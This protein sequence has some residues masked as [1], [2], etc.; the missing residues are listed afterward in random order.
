[1]VTSA[2]C[3]VTLD[4]IPLA[5]TAGITW[6]FQTGSQPYQTIFT[7][8]KRH[9]DEYLS[10]KK[11][12]PLT[13]EIQ[14]SRGS[15]LKIK[16]VYILYE[17]PSDSP[18]RS[19]FLVSD[20]RWKWQYQ[21]IVRDFNIPR[22]TGELQA[23]GFPTQS[24]SMN[25]DSWDFYQYSLKDQKTRWKAKEALEDV[26]EELHEKDDASYEISSWS[27][28]ESAEEDKTISL[29]NVLLRDQGDI[30]VGKL[31]GFIPGTDLYVDAEGVTQVYNAADMD[32][33]EEYFGKLPLVQWG[34]DAP[35]MVDRAAIRPS[36]VILH[37]DKEIE[38]L[39]LYRDD[40]A[41]GG[42]A[43][44]QTSWLY[45][46]N[47]CQT[48]DPKTTLDMYNDETGEI[49][50]DVEVAAGTWVRFDKWLEAMDKD[51]PEDSAPWTFETISR[52]WFVGNLE[53]IL[54]AGGN[55][56]DDT[57]NIAA[58]V[59]A[60][61]QHFRQTFRISPRIM[62][63]VREMAATRVTVLDPV[64]GLRAPAAAWPQACFIPSK[65]AEPKAPIGRNVDYY[66][67]A[68]G[69][70]SS[71]G[72]LHAA[73]F[74]LAAPCSVNM[75][76]ADLG[77]F[78]LEWLPNPKG[79]VSEVIPCHLVDEFMGQPAVLSRD[80]RE[81]DEKP[82]L[83]DAKVESGSNGLQLA[84][85]CDLN[86]MMTFVPAGNYPGQMYTQE[87][88]VGDLDKI[89]QKGARI[90]NGDGPELHIYVEPGEMTSR[91]A[92]DEDASGKSTIRDMLGLSGTDTAGLKDPTQM[93]GLKHLNEKQLETHAKS[94]ATEMIANYADGW[95]GNVATVL[96]EKKI[97]ELKGNMGSTTIRIASAPSGKVDMVS[98]FTGQQRPVSRFSVMPTSVRAQILGYVPFDRP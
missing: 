72:K 66:E 3:I 91:W 57:A 98:E 44:L 27:I 77:I 82:V 46:S 51:K 93:P 23:T 19:S 31:L 87:V 26:L 10:S 14:D 92:W 45:M 70:G 94:Y 36:K 62:G 79:L 58:R 64:S 34:S 48:V 29:Q 4:K 30:A 24:N 17:V 60:I 6:K 90:Q 5:A 40:Y 20:K 22:K 95:Q 52:Y 53:T 86:V 75:I 32:A 38:I 76:D 8:A 7:V 12:S 13:L 21:L 73:G 39:L 80:L 41:E 84:E 59:Q 42:E 15:Q 2:K 61:R 63:R 50:K 1:M 96:P 43:Y 11:G 28:K 25:V 74:G 68:K 9:W 85:Y 67:A 81:Q 49:E 55:E 88:S 16:Q 56:Y 37:Y 69:S 47:V 71:S 83:G 89:F 33:A 18:H 35:I 54:G 78:R 97:I 65:K